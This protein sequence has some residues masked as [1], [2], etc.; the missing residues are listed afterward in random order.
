[1]G[2]DCILVGPPSGDTIWNTFF[3]IAEKVITNLILKKP[4]VRGFLPF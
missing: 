4:H 2:W 3:A 1:M